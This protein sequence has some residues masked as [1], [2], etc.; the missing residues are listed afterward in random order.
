MGAGVPPPPALV[1]SPSLL[2]WA[3]SLTFESPMTPGEQGFM[4]PRAL[5]RGFF[6]SGYPWA[7]CLL[8]VLAQFWRRSW[9]LHATSSH[10][11]RSGLGH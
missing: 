11:V 5:A 1:A 10:P 3:G 6:P 4:A 7:P 2:L 8:L 9:D